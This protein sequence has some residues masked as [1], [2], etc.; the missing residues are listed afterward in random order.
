[1]LVGVGVG[2]ALNLT[3]FAAEESVKVGADLVGTAFLEGVA[4]SAAS[5]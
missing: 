2:E 5:L 3:S 4:L 1:M